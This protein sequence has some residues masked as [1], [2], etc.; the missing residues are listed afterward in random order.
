M[1]YF[2]FILFS[3]LTCTIPWSFASLFAP[4][5]LLL[6]SWHVQLFVIIFALFVHQVLILSQV[7]FLVILQ[8]YW[9]YVFFHELLIFWHVVFLVILLQF[10]HY[11]VVNRLICTVPCNPVIIFTLFFFHEFVILWHVLYFVLL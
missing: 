9:H 6:T 8:E 5:F 1:H 2:S 11:L 10:L 7:L 4:L 3:L